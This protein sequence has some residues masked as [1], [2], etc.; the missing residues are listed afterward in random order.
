MRQK[1]TE[2]GKIGANKSLHQ[3]V[4]GS[5]IA[6]DVGLKWIK[7]GERFVGIR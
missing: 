6:H 2:K 5:C 7:M 1:D 4:H 3:I